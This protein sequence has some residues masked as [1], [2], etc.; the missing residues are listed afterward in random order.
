MP[1]S[2]SPGS[3]TMRASSSTVPRSATAAS[4]SDGGAQ[5]GGRDLFQP[6]DQS[7]QHLVLIVGLNRR[8]RRPGAR[9]RRR[10]PKPGC[11]SRAR[12]RRSARAMWPSSNRSPEPSRSRRFSLASQTTAASPGPARCGRWR[13]RRGP[14]RLRRCGAAP[15]IPRWC[16]GWRRSAGSAACGRE[17]AG[18]ARRRCPAAIRPRSRTTRAPIRWPGRRVPV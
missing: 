15:C 9:G 1:A 11:G 7:A 4:R 2:R 8:I 5:A 16:A 14:G 12:W 18:R 10:R 6:V 17:S 13:A 3:M